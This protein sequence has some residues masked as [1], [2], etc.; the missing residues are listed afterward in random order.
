M[1]K[2]RRL[3]RQGLGWRTWGRVHL[4]WCPAPLGWPYHSIALSALFRGSASVST[5]HA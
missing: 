1:R 2:T 3:L 5:V 4:A